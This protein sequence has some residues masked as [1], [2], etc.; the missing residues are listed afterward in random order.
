MP[1]MTLLVLYLVSGLVLMGLAVPLTQRK[2]PPNGWYGFRIPR[3][4]NDPDVWYR[5][6]A[7][8]GRWLFATGLVT[9]IA[10]VVLALFPLSLDAYALSCTA[11]IGVMLLITLVQSVR[12]L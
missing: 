4:L 10:A 9:V 3:T 5:A 1:M 6:N 8:A 2:I 12:S 11:V 7:V